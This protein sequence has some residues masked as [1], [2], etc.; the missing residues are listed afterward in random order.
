MPLVPRIQ[1]LVETANGTLAENR[2]SVQQITTRL[3]EIT[4]KA[5]E[6]A[7]KA[8]DMA[9]RANELLDISKVQAVKIDALVSDASARA[10][11]QMDRAELVL[12]DTMGR[13][14][15]SVSTVHHGVMKPLREVAGVA[16]GVKAAV[17]TLLKGQRPSVDQVTQ[18]EEM[19]I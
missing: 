1:A 15:E 5:N 7:A 10:K 19:F 9:T 12:D 3:G 6:I 2:Q 14:Q 4:G 11:V 13:V 16:N 18:D 8:S 17:S